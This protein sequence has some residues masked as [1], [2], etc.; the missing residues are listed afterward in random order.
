MIETERLILRKVETTDYHNFYV[1][2]SNPNV[3]THLGKKHITDI[4]QAKINVHNLL[5]QY[6]NY[7][8]GRFVIIEKVTGSFVG[9]CG[10]KLVTETRNNHINFYDIGYRLVEQHWGKGFA[11]EASIA[12]VKYA[13]EQ[14]KLSNIY[15]ICELEN[16][17]SR[18]ILEKIGMQCI[19]MFDLDGTTQYWFVLSKQN[20]LLQ[21]TLQ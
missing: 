4:N 7:G 20:W 10:L 14:L 15:A 2:D 9:W 5:Q 18:N 17:A 3:H 12:C 19:E 1:L 11:T 13:F 21:S 16:K 8:V 6:T